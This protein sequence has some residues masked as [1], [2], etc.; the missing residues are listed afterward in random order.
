MLNF[1]P[2]ATVDNNTIGMMQAADKVAT[3]LVTFAARNSDFDGRKI[4]KGEIMALENGKIVSVGTDIPPG[5]QYGQKGY[6]LYH[7]DFGL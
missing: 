7:G 5:P 2:E 1:D 3:G 4:K 6:Q